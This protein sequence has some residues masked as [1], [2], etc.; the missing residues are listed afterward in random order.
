M[1][2]SLKRICALALGALALVFASCE[3]P[4]TGLFV[5]ISADPPVME[6]MRA[7]RVRVYS[8][9]NSMTVRSERTFPVA[10]P[11]MPLSFP[12]T[13]ADTSQKVRIEVEGFAVDLSQG[14]PNAMPI[15]ES[16]FITGFITGKV[17]VAPILLV[18]RCLDRVGAMGCPQ[19]RVCDPG[20]P[21][22]G[23][24]CGDPERP[25]N[26]L[27]E[28]SD[29]VDDPCPEGSFRDGTICRMPPGADGGMMMM[30]PP[31]G[32]MP[33]PADGGAPPRDTGSLPLPDTGLLADASAD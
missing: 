24:M 20:A 27:T 15:I 7:I 31:D 6:R 9:S 30:G 12:I 16:R 5:V 21:P 26:S 11:R 3:K 23:D 2:A 33:P 32:G 14:T 22:M 4:A 29:I 13:A 19:G 18:G 8:P 1:R 10:P 17:L 25:A 28:H